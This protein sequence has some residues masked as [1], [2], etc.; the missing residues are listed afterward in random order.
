MIAIAHGCMAVL[1]IAAAAI[2]LGGTAL[3]W[4]AAFR[5][6]RPK[7]APD[8]QDEYWADIDRRRRG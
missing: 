1:I 3:I 6:S 4:T 7:P 8:H 5:P 2:F